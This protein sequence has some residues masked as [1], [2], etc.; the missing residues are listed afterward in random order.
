MSDYW[1][2]FREP[3]QADHVIGHFE[4]FSY[5]GTPQKKKINWDRLKGPTPTHLPQM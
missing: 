4:Y 5:V 3:N 1:F 2:V